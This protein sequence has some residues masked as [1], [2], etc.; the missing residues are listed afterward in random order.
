MMQHKKLININMKLVSLVVTA[1]LLSGCQSIWPDYVRPKVVVPATY[2]ETSD[3]DKDQANSPISNTW[4][5]LYQ[6]PV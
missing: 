4:W 6:D 5:T 1:A 2:S 3:Q